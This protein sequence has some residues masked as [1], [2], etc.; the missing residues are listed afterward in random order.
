MPVR[1]VDRNLRLRGESRTFIYRHG[2]DIGGRRLCRDATAG[3]L[4][5]IFRIGFCNPRPFPPGVCMEAVA[6]CFTD[7]SEIA[8][9]APGARDPPTFLT[10]RYL[11]RLR[12]GLPFAA[13]PGWLRNSRRPARSPRTCANSASTVE[14][15]RAISRAVAGS[16]TRNLFP[17][18]R[19]QDFAGSCSTTKQHLPASRC[20]L[21]SASGCTG[22]PDGNPVAGEIR[23]QQLGHQDRTQR[24]G[25]LQY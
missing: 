25:F 14:S 22:V 1:P 5:C 10:A 9:Q 18:S 4:A 2:R 3:V 16:S 21:P 20:E 11:S 17:P 6:R 7:V 13:E 24:V 23:D 19:R 12:D 15:T 8:A